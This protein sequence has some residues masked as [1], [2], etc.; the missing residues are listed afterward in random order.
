T[1]LGTSNRV[2]PFNYLR[3]RAN[4]EYYTTDETATVK[5]IYQKHMLDA[6]ICIGGDGTMTIADGLS[7]MGLNVVGI[8]KTI[9]NDVYG[10]DKSFGFETA[11][12][13]ATDAI[14]RLHTTAMSHHRVM[15]VEVMGRN[16]GWLA[17][18]SGVA[19]GGDIILIPEIGYDIE[20]VCRKVVD[21]SGRGDRFSIVVVAEGAKE[22]QGEVVVDR[23]VRDVAEPLRL[24]G[25]G[26]KV[27][28][29]I[30]DMAEIESR[31]TALGHLQ[32]GGSP[33]PPDR[34]LGTLFGYKAV[35]LVVNGEFGRMV[36][37]RG[38]N[39]ESVDISTAAGRQRLVPADYHLI[40]AA[41]CIGTSFGDEA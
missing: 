21:R 20:A 22:K 15:V 26:R 3:K 40:E 27:A 6:L 11:V 5:K 13:I 31:V 2:D 23:V 33:S 24:G 38:E 14:D 1:M 18:T 34:V 17:L 4:G 28:D 25:I 19:G 9:D 29:Q 39:I 12:G 32:R 7:D 10:T 8:P 16:A 30:E 37:L 36:S 35:E 41:R